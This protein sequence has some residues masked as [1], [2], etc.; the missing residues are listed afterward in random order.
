MDIRRSSRRSFSASDSQRLTIKALLFAILGAFVLLIAGKFGWEASRTWESES[1]AL[2]QREFDAAANKFV[3]GIYEILLVRLA[4]NNALQAAAADT[5]AISAIEVGRRSI[6]D[7]YDSGLAVIER[8]QFPDKVA[9]LLDLKGKREKANEYQRQADSA[10]RLARDQRDDNLRQTFVPVMTDWVNASLR[11]WYAALYSTA[12][13]DARLTQLAAIKE[14]GW[15][16]REFSGLERSNVAAAISAGVPISAER[17]AANTEFRA[18]VTALWQMLEDLTRDPEILSVLA[19]PMSLA[20]DQYF[21]GFLSLS[22]EMRKAGEAGK[23]PM[24]ASQWVERTNPQIDSLLAVMHAAG[25]ASEAHTSKTLDLALDTFRDELGMLVLA[26]VIAAASA[27]SIIWRVTRPLST[28]TSAM[29]ELSDGNFDVELPGLGRK[30]EVGD[31]AQAVEVFKV[32]AIEKAAREAEEKHAEDIRV[33]ARRKADM[34]RVADDFEAAVSTIVGAVSSASTQLESA[35]NVLTGNAETAQKLSGTVAAASRQASASVQSAA[36]ATQEMTSSVGEIARQVEESS[37]IAADAVRQAGQTDA[38]IGQLS[39]AAG[40][41]GE[42]VKLIT[43]IAEQTNL[44]ALNATIEAARAGEA[45]RGF[46]VVA[47]EVKALASQTARATDDIGA[48]IADMQTATQDSVA[49]IKEIGAT[50][51]R[52]ADNAATIAAAVSEQR[53]ANEEIARNVFQAANGTQEVAA[54]ITDVNSAAGATGSASME[55]LTSAR[56]LSSDSSRL[57]AQVERFLATVRAA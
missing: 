13:G 8:R 35:A 29:H 48:Q 24:T 55:V 34:D 53:A 28:L 42:V 45:G 40:R 38:R 49:A 46:A 10:L 57:K 39:N 37:R 21:K 36:T 25:A 27:A 11:V 41:I 31:M 56:S 16:M 9:L 18:R 43:A 23:Y 54:N 20:Q 7:L 51:G 44:L 6:D 30:D 22:D 14:I 15:K 19:D 17:L 50:I 5:G 52:I 12:Q 1:R 47:Q 2:D 33:A 32:K 26:F 4:T 3:K